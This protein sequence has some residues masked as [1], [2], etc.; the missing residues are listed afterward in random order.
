M[1]IRTDTRVHDF[2]PNTPLEETGTT[3]AAVNAVVFTK[4]LIAAHPAV[5]RD[6]KRS[7]CTIVYKIK[8]NWKMLGDL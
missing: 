1:Y 5:H 6:R 2:S 3:V 4:R 7:S 8:N